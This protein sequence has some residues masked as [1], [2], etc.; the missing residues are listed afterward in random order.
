MDVYEGGG[1]VSLLRLAR[2]CVE[3]G[4]R[5]GD[6]R[7]VYCACAMFYAAVVDGVVLG[8]AYAFTGRVPAKGDCVSCFLQRFEFREVVCFLWVRVFGRVL[9][10][11]CSSFCQWLV[12]VVGGDSSS[13]SFFLRGGS[14]VGC[15]SSVFC[16]D[17]RVGVFRFFRFLVHRVVG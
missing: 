5:D 7:A 3:R 6:V 14:F 11:G 8:E 2:A 13:G 9:C 15:A 12:N 17:A 1:L 16:Q 10:C 4:C